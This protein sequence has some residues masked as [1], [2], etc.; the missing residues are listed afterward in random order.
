V[1]LPRRRRRGPGGLYPQTQS[2]CHEPLEF[3]VPGQ[4][5]RLETGTPR[6]RKRADVRSAARKPGAARPK[7]REILMVSF[8]VV[9]LPSILFDSP[10][11]T[12]VGPEANDSNWERAGSVQKASH[13]LERQRRARS[14]W[15]DPVCR[16][17]R[18]HA[19]PPLLCPLLLSAGERCL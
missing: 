5:T 16:R 18:P 11:V 10:P 6:C 3:A 8:E 17:R 19:I 9:R 15:L 1:W 14:K 4:S 7:F 13:R 12:Q 2:V